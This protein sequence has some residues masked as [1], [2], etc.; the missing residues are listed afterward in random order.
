M[1]IGV[2]DHQARQQLAEHL[3]EDQPEDRG[4]LAS[5]N[6]FGIEGPKMP[7]MVLSLSTLLGGWG[8]AALGIAAPEI[9]ASFGI[10]IVAL[11]LISTV[12]SSLL[13][14]LG[15]P[16]GYLVDRVNRVRL[17][18][19]A[20]FAAP[21]G[22][23]ISAGA[24]GYGTF[25][26]GNALGT[27]A[28]TPASGADMP[29]LSDWYPT[30]S[31]ARVFGFLSVAGAVGG[32]I[33]TP[34]VGFIVAQYGWRWATMTLSIIGFVVA[35]LTLLL[36]E[37]A[38]GRM[39]RL[40]L[41]GS[42]ER[43]EDEPPAPSFTEALRGAWSIKT[44]RLQAIGGFVMTF[45]GPLN[46]LLSL[47]LASRFALGPFERSLIATV[48]TL[49][50]IPAVLI[51]TAVADRLLARKPSSVVA[52]QAVVGLISS[53]IMVA[54]AFAPNL[55]IFVTL[56]VTG[57]ILPMVLSPIGFTITSMVV[58]ARYR[59]VGM[60][61]FTPF[62]L[63]GTLMGPAL[64]AVS[65]QVTLQ[66][67]FLF[68][69]PFMVLSSLIILASAGHV[70]GDIRAAKA[71]AVAE[72]DAAEIPDESA[73]LLLV[74]RDLEATI[75]GA[76]ILASVDLDVRRGEIV[77]LTG[78]NGAG[79]STLLKAICGLQPSSNGAVFFGGLNVTHMPDHQLAGKGMAYIPGGEGI[80]ADLSVREHL[81]LAEAYARPASAAEDAP[82][83]SDGEVLEY[84]PA[85][86]DR[87]DTRAADLSGGEQQML[88]L[89]QGFVLRPSLMLIDELS[90]GLAP[91]VV[92]QLLASVRR[93][94]ADG[95]TIVV[96]EQSINLALRLADQ[97]VYLDQGAVTFAGTPDQF[98]SHPELVHAQFLGRAASARLRAR[99]RPVRGERTAV[100]RGAGLT[101]DYGGVRALD[102]VDLE[103]A[104]GEIVGV[105]GS[106][107]AG[108]TTL[109]DVL[110]G[111]ESASAGRVFLKDREITG[112]SPDARARLGLARAFQN[113]RLFG[114][115]SVR[116][117]IAVALEKDAAK[118]ALGAA[119]WFPTVRACERRLQ[120]RVDSL[121]EVFGL[122][123]YV[124]MPILELSTGT[125]RAVEVACQL[126]MEPT[127]LLLDEPA[128]G[129]AQA[130]VENLGPALQRIV[131]DTGCGIVLIEHD[132]PLLGGVSDRLI[133]LD[134][135]Q[136][137]AE[138][139]PE[140]VLTDPA[141][142]ASYL[143]ASAEAVHR[144]GVGVETYGTD[145][146][147]NHQVAPPHDRPRKGAQP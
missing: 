48:T 26:G 87:L 128:S 59:G 131:R 100:L 8:S 127:V 66:Q 108:K 119:L 94:K 53:G 10:S 92:D 57:A 36:R 74:V 114:P 43:M 99:T 12:Q 60:Q 49:F 51:G 117:T 103:V 40:E 38:R 98:R 129:L 135:G 64:L 77:A 122:S 45:A 143:D 89:A 85:L 30:N 111:Y 25:L 75:D 27:L 107:G 80:F 37:P 62:A 52:L 14:I 41:T 124:D 113:A 72:R 24:R 126:A 67:A 93:L 13:L 105:I 31:R 28:T 55:V 39:D 35:G 65:G 123:D 11:T 106:N 138:G 69:A 20:A 7:L 95:M 42:A 133:A 101:V 56:S 134:R 121:I 47:I 146:P 147:R 130:E 22:D 58:P 33:S 83:S 1:T 137:I 5:I 23:M 70:T 136:V 120:E 86:R 21:V 71:A 34:I 18:Q 116:E 145:Q 73:E 144:S 19:I 61:V 2:R 44:L 68:F 54:Q 3:R 6:P 84:F 17:V 97:I 112:L 4:W 15:L 79:K 115:L 118:N 63:V 141:V 9:Q 76:T 90:L 91:A 142:M 32:L 102:H 16:L 140:S 46:I 110:S 78:T 125:R 82:G 96:V 81:R 139:A 29:L 50:S 104:G 88:A 109:F 132:L